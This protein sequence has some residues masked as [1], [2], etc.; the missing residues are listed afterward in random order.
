[1]SSVVR[2]ETVASEKDLGRGV[3]DIDTDLRSFSLDLIRGHIVLKEIERLRKDFEDL[4]AIKESGMSC[5]VLRCLN[6]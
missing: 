2:A 1:M 4:H 5:V 3:D 6:V